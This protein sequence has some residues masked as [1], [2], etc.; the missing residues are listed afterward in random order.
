MSHVLRAVVVVAVAAVAIILYVAFRASPPQATRAPSIDRAIS[1]ESP[2]PTPHDA[3]PIA[4]TTAGDA[5]T[6][7]QTASVETE[8]ATLDEPTTKPSAGTQSISG[9]IVVVDAEGVEHRTESG[10][11][12]LYDSDGHGAAA[13]TVGVAAGSWRAEVGVGATLS[14][15]RIVLGEHP[16]VW[17]SDDRQFQSVVDNP[18][19]LRARWPARSLL[20]VREAAT[21]RELP[22]VQLIEGHVWSWTSVSTTHPGR[23][24]GRWFDGLASPIDLSELLVQPTKGPPS[25]Y[26]VANLSVR[27]AG[28]AWA[29]IDVDLSSGGERFLDLVPGGDV[30]VHLVGEADLDGASLRV[31][32]VERPEGRPYAQVK[33]GTDREIALESMVPGAYTMSVEFGVSSTGPVV[34]G[35]AAVQVVAGMRTRVDVVVRERPKLERVQLAGIQHPHAEMDDAR[36]DGDDDVFPFHV[37]ALSP[38]RYEVETDQPLYAAVIDVPD[39]GRDDVMIEIPPPAHVSIRVVDAATGSDAAVE[40]VLWYTAIAAENGGGTVND[41]R[42]DS[43]TAR[44]EF[45]APRTTIVA[46]AGG[47]A[48]SGEQLRLDLHDG[49]NEGEIRVAA[50][51]GVRLRVVEG[52]ATLPWN[53]EWRPRLTALDG[54][55]RETG[56][57]SDGRGHTLIV[58]KPGRYRLTMK[59][60][61]GY[62][63]VP[64]QEITIGE[65]QYAE[66]VLHLE[67]EP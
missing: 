25:I 41:A 67:R 38:G 18:I 65:G 20:H 50:T 21:G 47:I 46:W 2:T 23:A 45:D 9:T 10:S 49:R 15:Q 27:S 55:G 12:R 39:G 4:A 54:D 33:L 6:P 62:R 43:S 14:V 16:A 63:D 22:S 28:L 34:L 42:R 37:A 11:F 13:V 51:C 26:R 1:V 58:T 24:A 52:D 59:K 29:R 48:H 7:T 36:S 8:P 19:E 31:R 3:T 57:S 53:W 44:F 40:S 66:V 60:I 30:D 35:S 17:V 32:A 5:P 64:E 56:N 61:D